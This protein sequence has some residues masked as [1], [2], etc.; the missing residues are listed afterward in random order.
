M[1]W[2]RTQFFNSTFWRLVFSHS[3]FR[4]HLQLDF[5]SLEMNYEPLVWEHQSPKCFGGEPT[6]HNIKPIVFVRIGILLM[7]INATSPHPG[8]TWFPVPVSQLAEVSQRGYRTLSAHIPLLS[9]MTGLKFTTRALIL[10]TKYQTFIYDPI[11]W[12]SGFVLLSGCLQKLHQ[13]LLP[14]WC[15]N[16]HVS[17]PKQACHLIWSLIQTFGCC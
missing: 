2:E 1:W 7:G 13:F 3:W 6:I 17:T 14:L 12:L 9:R 16:M 15:V 11:L 5:V 10:A 4:I 8:W